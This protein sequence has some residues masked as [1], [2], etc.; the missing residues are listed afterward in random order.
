MLKERLFATD[1]ERN[2]LKGSAKGVTDRFSSEK[3][4][5]KSCVILYDRGQPAVYGK[6]S[7][8]R[9]SV[10]ELAGVC[11]QASPCCFGKRPNGAP[12]TQ[13]KKEG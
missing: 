9:P 11:T 8:G 2:R 5:V 12:G 3:N 13:R 4:Q 10:C 1:A 7:V 6:D